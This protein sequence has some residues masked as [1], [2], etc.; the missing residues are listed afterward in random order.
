MLGVWI[1]IFNKCECLSWTLFQFGTI[2]WIL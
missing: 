1:F 2:H